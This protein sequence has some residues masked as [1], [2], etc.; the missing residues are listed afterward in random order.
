MSSLAVALALFIARAE[1]P[2]VTALVKSSPALK[3]LATAAYQS[4]YRRIGH[5]K[6][7]PCGLHMSHVISQKMSSYIIIYVYDL[8]RCVSTL[9]I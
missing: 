7:C 2:A 8:R 1:M 6:G 9:E 4:R 3:T 5:R